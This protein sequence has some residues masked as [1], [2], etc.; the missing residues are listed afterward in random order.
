LS[1]AKRP[2]KSGF[3]QKKRTQIFR[4]KRIWRIDITLIA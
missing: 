3:A 1:A 2:Q 4:E